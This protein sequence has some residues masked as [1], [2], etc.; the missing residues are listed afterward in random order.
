MKA[1]NAAII[2]GLIFLAVGLL[3]YTSNPIIGPDEAMF[4]TDS[5]HNIVHL[6]SGA[7]FLLV[8][9]A[10][11]GSVRSFLKIFGVVYFFLGI[12]GL[13]TIGSDGTTHLLGFLHVN[14]AD[15]Y[16]HIALGLVIFLA[17]MLGESKPIRV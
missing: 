13:F 2:I 15:N 17:G 7:L 6:V 4:H 11:P 5:L 14:G 16:L 8:A 1:K 12:L 3:G 9:F 10:F